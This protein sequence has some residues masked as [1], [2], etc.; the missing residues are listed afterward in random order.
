MVLLVCTLVCL[1]LYCDRMMT[2]E[3]SIVVVV[4]EVVVKEVQVYPP[5][6]VWRKVVVWRR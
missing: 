6:V 3:R 2:Q 5:V 4:L 1:S